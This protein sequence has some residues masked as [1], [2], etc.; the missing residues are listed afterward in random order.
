MTDRKML[1]SII[2]LWKVEQQTCEN[3][4]LSPALYIVFQYCLFSEAFFRSVGITR[5]FIFM[6]MATS[7]ATS[8][9]LSV[10]NL[11]SY[12]LFCIS[13]STDQFYVFCVDCVF[14]KNN[15]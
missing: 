15:N 7:V 9:Y 10:H 14:S 6:K 2:Y 12:F 1:R 5:V 4:M 8:G 11:R 3:K 13:V